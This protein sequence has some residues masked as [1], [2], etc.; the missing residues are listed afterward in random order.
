M[1]L[2][3]SVRLPQ[4][5]TSS[6]NLC[7]ALVFILCNHVSRA[8]FSHSHDC[9]QEQR[10][11]NIT[12]STTHLSSS[13]MNIEWSPLQCAKSYK[14]YK[15]YRVG[16]WTEVKNVTVN[17]T[18]DGMLKSTIYNISQCE[19]YKFAIIAILDQGKEIQIVES[20]GV[21]S[22]CIVS[23][24]LGVVVFVMASIVLVP[25]F[26]GLVLKRL[27]NRPSFNTEQPK[28]KNIKA[29]GKNYSQDILENVDERTH[30]LNDPLSS[31]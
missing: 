7:L 9:A 19:T 11:N 30:E 16:D 20:S 31:T 17:V 29:L 25:A 21:R 27:E 22:E 12:I 4:Q 10:I 3:K 24:V 13:S 2:T 28:Y 15:K 23:I 5:S 8:D 18:E 26:I 1:Y 6:L 14:V